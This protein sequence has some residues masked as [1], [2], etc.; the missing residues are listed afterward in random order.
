VINETPLIFTGRTSPD[1]TFTCPIASPERLYIVSQLKFIKTHEN[2]FS[3][4]DIISAHVITSAG[5]T[6]PV[7]ISPVICS[8]G[9]TIPET[10]SDG[11]S[12][13]HETTSVGTSDGTT[14]S[15]GTSGVIIGSF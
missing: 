6:S 11:I 7:I 3:S 2:R 5:I 10:I 4:P 14:T 12:D 9:T 8:V 1:C 13:V 15:A